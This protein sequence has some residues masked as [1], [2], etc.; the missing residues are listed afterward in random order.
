MSEFHGVVG[1]TLDGKCRKCGGNMVA[2][3][4]IQQTLTGTP[5]FPGD[6]TAVTLSPG[7]S[8]KL[9]DCMKCDKCGWSVTDGR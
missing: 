3:K 9:I 7:G 5:D 8:G 4:A 1:D 2:G 6:T